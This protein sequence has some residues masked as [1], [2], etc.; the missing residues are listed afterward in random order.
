MHFVSEAWVSLGWK[1]IIKCWGSRGSIPVSGKQ[2]LH[3]GGN[4]TCLEIRTNDDKILIIDAGSGI[5]ELGNSLIVAGR[6]EFTLLLTHAHWDHIMGF[7]FFKPI[8]SRKTNLNI[9]GCPF[10][11]ASIKEMLVRVMEAPNFPVNFDAIHANISYQDTCVEH[12]TLGSMIITP[13]ALS[14]PNQGTGYKFEED[15]KCFVFLTDNELG[16]KHEGGLD[17]QAY[18]EFS[19]DADLLFHDAEYKEEEYKKTRS[20]GHSVYTDTLNL[21]LDAGVKKLGLFHHNQE[22][23]DDEIDAIVN[24][25]RKIIKKS[26]KNLECFAVWQSMEFKL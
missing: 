20:W 7:P 8:Y 13:I 6:N 22:R 19:R 15:G 10:A 3:Y 16:Y 14:H 18:L 2:Y 11:Q 17:S 23:I 25:C 24:D 26:G 4:T 21:A 12:Y 5:R 1:M 9:W